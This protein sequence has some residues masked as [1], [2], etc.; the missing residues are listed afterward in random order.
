[1]KMQYYI[2]STPSLQEYRELLVKMESL[3]LEYRAVNEILRQKYTPD[4]LISF[5][6]AKREIIDCMMQSVLLVFPELKRIPCAIYL[7]GSY[8]RGSITAGSDLDILFLLD[9]ENVDSYQGQI[10]LIRNAIAK[11]F[12][13]SV[14]HIHSFMKNFTTESRKSNGNCILDQELTAVVTW[15]N[16]GETF[17]VNYP[18]NQSMA[19]R[20]MCEY[21]SVK[22]WD[23]FCET[24]KTKMNTTTAEWMYSFR[25]I[26]HNKD[27]FD[28]EAYIRQM[29]QRGNEYIMN[30]L[31]RS[32]RQ[33]LAEVHDIMRYMNELEM[34]QIINL[35]DFCSY[36]KRRVLSA[37]HNLLAQYRR[38]QRCVSREV[39]LDGSLVIRRYIQALTRDRCVGKLIAYIGEKY[40]LYRYLISRH[41]I[42]LS[43]YNHHF[44]HRSKESI[45][46]AALSQEYCICW[47]TGNDDL[48]Q[49]IRTAKEILRYVE[50]VLILLGKSNRESTIT[51]KQR[52][53]L[54]SEY[55]QHHER[56]AA[57]KNRMI[58]LPHHILS[59][60]LKV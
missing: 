37:V 9:R 23:S 52:G 17:C 28:A 1:M 45:E 46:K 4:L 44:E 54:P 35:A 40:N 60:E 55:R 2:D 14:V 57:S 19:E 24:M 20:E 56:I 8:A 21:L 58:I 11:V 43:T 41:E 13:V 48:S 6:K 39:N 18:S 33:L 25:R 30:H 10:Y 51:F 3:S 15:K 22:D 16:T 34:N 36:G 32:N 50:F 47:G 27:K 49:L 42:A 53:E 38:G 29:E 7:N 59:R 31:F 26:Y 5:E 12:G